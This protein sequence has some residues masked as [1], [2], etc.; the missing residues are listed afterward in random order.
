MQ[1]SFR[2]GV[3]FAGGLASAPL[4]RH[5]HLLEPE[6]VTEIKE[7]M[8]HSLPRQAKVEIFLNQKQHQ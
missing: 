5:L 1:E 7:P 8:A 2:P 3:H 6:G 4:T